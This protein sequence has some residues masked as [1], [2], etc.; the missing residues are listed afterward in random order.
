M[1]ICVKINEFWTVLCPIHKEECFKLLF[2]NEVWYRLAK[3]HLFE[4]PWQDEDIQKQSAFTQTIQT[5]EKKKAIRIV[6]TVGFRDHSNT[7]FLKSY[8]L[9]LEDIPATSQKIFANQEEGYNLR[10]N[11]L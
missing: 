6:H 11:R 3:T 5:P 8:A 7:L 1:K 4:N 2:M 9:K 10:V